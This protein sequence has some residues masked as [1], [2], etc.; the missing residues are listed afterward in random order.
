MTKEERHVLAPFED[1]AGLRLVAASGRYEGLE[2]ARSVP[3]DPLVRALD[4]AIIRS[5]RTGFGSSSAGP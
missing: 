5:A 2:T 3:L 4:Q 1:P